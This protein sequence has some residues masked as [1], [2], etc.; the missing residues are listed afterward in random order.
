MNSTPIYRSEESSSCKKF[1]TLKNGI[2]VNEKV[3]TLQDLIEKSS[4][5]WNE[6]EWEF[7]KW[8]RNYKETDMDCA[9]R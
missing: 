2:T 6:Q 7:P 4:T 5:S 1:E 9:F 8:R 3:V